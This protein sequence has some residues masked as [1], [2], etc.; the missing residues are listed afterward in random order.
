M[1]AYHFAMAS[2]WMKNG[3][4]DEFIKT[5]WNANLFELVGF[6]SYS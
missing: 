6:Y 2:E 5:H 3:N 1:G 4:I